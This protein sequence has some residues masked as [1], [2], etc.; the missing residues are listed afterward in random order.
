MS[1]VYSYDSLRY[2]S[3]WG[4]DK[5]LYN[6]FPVFTM[7]YMSYNTYVTLYIYYTQPNN[8]WIKISIASSIRSLGIKLTWICV[9]VILSK[10]KNYPVPGYGLQLQVKCYTYLFILNVFI[11][12]LV[13]YIIFLIPYLLWTNLCLYP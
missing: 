8:T 1:E 9:S 10:L 12:V 2:P 3:N 6:K 5:Y 13:K 7:S 4:W 11:I